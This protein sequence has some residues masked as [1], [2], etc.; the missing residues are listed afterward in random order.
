MSK[1]LF[2]IAAAM[3]LATSPAWAGDEKSDEKAAS[4][5]VASTESVAKSESVTQSAT[6]SAVEAGRASGTM[7]ESNEVR[8]SFEERWLRERE[9]Y[10]DGGY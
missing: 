5:T 7:K 6:D 4:H 2:G 1:A 8:A 10:R 9:G 3:A